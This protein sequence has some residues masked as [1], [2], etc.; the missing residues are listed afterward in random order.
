M[1]VAGEAGE[2]LEHSQWLT[3]DQSHELDGKNRQEVIEELADVLIILSAWL[4]SSMLTSWRRRNTSSQSTKIPNRGPY[5]NR[6][7]NRPI[8]SFATEFK[9]GTPLI[10]TAQGLCFRN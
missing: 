3:E 9:H 4:I 7:G 1:A 8:T 10:V 6:L 2:L 5:A